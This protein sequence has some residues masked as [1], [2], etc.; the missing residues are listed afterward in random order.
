MPLKL[1]IDSLKAEAAGL[2]QLLD[3]GERYGDVVGQL[4]YKERLA[5]IAL[6]LEEMASSDRHL[7]SI[8]LFFSGKPVFG[9]RG[10]AVDFAGKLL[11]AYQDLVSKTFAKA[12]IGVLGERGRVPLKGDTGLMVTGLTHGSFGFVLEELA[13]QA[14]MH[15]TA[16]KEVLLMVSELLRNVSSESEIEFD[17][18]TEELD[19]RTLVALREFFKNMDT[20]EAAVR[21]VEDTREFSLDAPAI[22]RGRIR[23]EATEI[24]EATQSIS[25]ILAGFLPDH[26]RFELRI[27]S[28]ETFYGTTSKEAAEQF[29]HAVQK[30]MVLIGAPCEAEFMVREIRPLNRPPRRTYRLSQFHKLGTQT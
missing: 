26:R 23:T 30:D 13:D 14:E 8:A 4:Q 18:V 7:A 6:T 28:G 11:E 29:E 21:F 17:R 12:E 3:E 24:D 16:L 15:D 25:G 2:R 5:E 20:A 1:T 22:H 10:I 9:S 19:S 27:S